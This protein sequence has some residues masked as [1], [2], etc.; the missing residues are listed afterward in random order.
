MDGL[1]QVKARIRAKVG[2]AFCV[3]KRPFGYVRVR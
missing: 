2:H 1:E 3:I